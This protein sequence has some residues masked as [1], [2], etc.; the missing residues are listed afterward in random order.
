DTNRHLE[1]SLQAD[2]LQRLAK[3]VNAV[4]THT[5]DEKVSVYKAE[6][7]F[8]EAITNVS[9]DLRTPL[10]YVVGYIDMLESGKIT[11]V[12]RDEYFQ[13]VKERIRHLV[14]MLDDLFEFARIESGEYAL[15]HEKIDVGQTFLEIIYLFQ[16][17]FANK[18]AEPRLNLPEIPLYINADI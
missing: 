10:T 6:K 13:I 5:R 15:T 7:A 8:K 4:L 9:H 3:H 16:Y 12:E 18:K 1:L 2:D 17:E 11:V 14:Q